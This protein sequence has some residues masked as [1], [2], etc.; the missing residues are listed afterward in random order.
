MEFCSG[1]TVCWCFGFVVGKVDAKSYWINILLP[2][3]QLAI[4]IAQ[5]SN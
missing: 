2:C 1:L 5:V 4:K 3:V